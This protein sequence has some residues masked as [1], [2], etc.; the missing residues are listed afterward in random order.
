MTNEE[1]HERTTELYKTVSE[2]QLE[3][4]EIRQNCPHEEF[5]NVIY[6]A[7]IGD[8]HEAAV[9]KFCGKYLASGHYTVHPDLYK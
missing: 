8:F 1:I 4:D 5:E 2:T 9:C 6:S 7:R 3:I